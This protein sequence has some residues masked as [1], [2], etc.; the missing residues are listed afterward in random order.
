MNDFCPYCGN[1]FT[2]PD[3]YIGHQIHC[4]SCK[5]GIELINL[6]EGRKSNIFLVGLV[7]GVLFGVLGF[8]SGTFITKPKRNEINTRVEQVQVESQKT[9]EELKM[10]ASEVQIQTSKVIHAL[11]EENRGL[12]KKYVS[13]MDIIKNVT[14]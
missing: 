7:F 4:P 8:V 1:E 3:K 14:L 2:V 12:N 6:Q 11:Q 9:I 5:K 13:A 10:K